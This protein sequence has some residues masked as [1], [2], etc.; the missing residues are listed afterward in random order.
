PLWR[1]EFLDHPRPG[2]WYVHATQRRQ[3]D[4]AAAVVHVEGALTAAAG[5][6]SEAEGPVAGLALV[7]GLE[8]GQ[9]V[10]P[11][12]DC[13]RVQN[14]IERAVQQHPR[15]KARQRPEGVGR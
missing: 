15:S 14:R 9:G 2:S 4:P 6:L 10:E 3:H 1:Y 11:G 12:A 13:L 5:D 8:A 7:A